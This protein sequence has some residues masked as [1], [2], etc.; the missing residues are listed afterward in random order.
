M[1]RGEPKVMIDTPES[2]RLLGA[3]ARPTL[4]D[5]PLYGDD[6]MVAATEALE[7]LA[8]QSAKDTV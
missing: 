4:K 8:S 7:L 3:S 2:C 6:I 5:L 1:P